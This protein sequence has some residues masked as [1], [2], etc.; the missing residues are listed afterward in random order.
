MG[1]SVL[2]GSMRAF[3]TGLTCF[4]LAS[5]MAASP[6]LAAEAKK[7]DKDKKPEVAYVNISPVAIPV[8]EGGQIINYVFVSV[9]LNLKP[10][11]NVSALRDKEPFFRDALVRSAWRQPFNDPTSYAKIDVGALKTR[12][13]GEATRIAGPGAVASVE[14][15]GDPQAKRVTGLPRPKGA[16]P[17]ERAP[18]P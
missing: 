18:I 5:A 3:L 8:L 7:G 11:A 9:R 10:T 16:G 2:D 1:E 13:M 15:I 4:T 12:M 14:I 17:V 6:V